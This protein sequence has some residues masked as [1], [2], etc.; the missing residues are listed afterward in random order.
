MLETY[1]SLAM[2]S[3]NGRNFKGGTYRL[4]EEI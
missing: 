1:L 3:G 2:L 4:L